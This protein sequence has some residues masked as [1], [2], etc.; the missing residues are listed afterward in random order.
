MSWTVHSK[1]T[2]RHCPGY[3][4]WE[5]EKWKRSVVTLRRDPIASSLPWKHNKTLKKV[6]ESG[7]KG[8]LFLMFQGVAES[9]N[10]LEDK[11]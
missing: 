11:F 2:W 8:K 5:A 1:G 9:N 10:K 3:L 4:K 7:T 6:E